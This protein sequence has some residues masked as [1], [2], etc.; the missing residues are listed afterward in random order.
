MVRV[1]ARFRAN[2]AAIEDLQNRLAF[3]SGRGRSSAEG[4]LVPSSTSCPGVRQFGVATAEHVVSIAAR[5]EPFG[6]DSQGCNMGVFSGDLS[7]RAEREK[8][9]SSYRY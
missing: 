6:E 2:G 7:F 1:F 5:S 3:V 8:I 9:V 4:R